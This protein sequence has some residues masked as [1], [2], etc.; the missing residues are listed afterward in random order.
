MEPQHSAVEADYRR[1][2]DLTFE[3]FRA[4][5]R[6]EGLS[7]Y[8]QI[9]FPDAY[10]RGHEEAIFADM[11]A[12]LTNLHGRGKV[13]LDI[14]PGC[15]DLP[16]LMI[17]LC[18]RQGHTL[19]LCDSAEMLAHL[20]DAPGVVKIPGRYPDESGPIFDEFRGGVDAI[21]CYSVL[22]YVFVEQPL[23]N[24][25]DRSLELLGEGGQMLLGDIPNVSKRKRFFRSGAGVGCHQH[26]TGTDEVPAVEFNTPEVGKLDDAVILGIL[27]RCRA[28]GFDAYIVP[29]A[30]GLPMANR[31]ED[32]LIHRP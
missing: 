15:S 17:D 9:G 16:R 13:I 22:H 25:V 6:S 1:F 24:F 11:T 12:K 4:L 18:L 3:G 5:A 27:A 23:F 30:P 32:I 26:Y 14:G 28:A 21:L 2:K 19:L 29:Q 7:R 10:R 31:R 20:H 8:Q